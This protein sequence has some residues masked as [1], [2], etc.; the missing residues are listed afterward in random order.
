MAYS[1]LSFHDFLQALLD[2]LD[3][4]ESAISVEGSALDG[5]LKHPSGVCNKIS[6]EES[7]KSNMAR[8]RVAAK[9]QEEADLRC[10]D[11]YYLV[12]EVC[13]KHKCSNN[14]TNFL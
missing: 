5:Q 9:E 6:G 1:W 8:N 12:L 14:G 3:Q 13:V 11:P 4:V 10:S 7:V 2:L